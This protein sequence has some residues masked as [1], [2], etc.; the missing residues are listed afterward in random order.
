MPSSFDLRPAADPAATA[1]RTLAVIASTM[2][3]GSTLLKALLQEAPDISQL[4][5]INFQRF[6]SPRREASM[7]GLDDRPIL[8]LKRPAWYHESGRYPRLPG[9]PQLRVIALVRDCYDT[10]E[11]LRKMTFRAVHSWASPVVDRWL[12]TR[13]WVRVSR[14]L[15]ELSE[16]FPDAG[17][18]SRNPSSAGTCP[19]VRLVRYEDLVRQPIEITADL[20]AFLGSQQTSGV[21]SYSPPAGYRWRWGTDDNSPQ[22]RSLRVQTPKEKAWTNL[23][24][25]T[26]IETSPEIADLRQRLG[27]FQ[28]PVPKGV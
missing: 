7:W 23:R 16:R 17:S 22:I 14:R 5:E 6:A 2:R 11:S 12:A 24:L 13:Y 8:L 21:D 9:V 4:S 28:E 26:C 3:S 25:K 19:C 15:L 18:A 1:D 10:V 27:Y 20:F